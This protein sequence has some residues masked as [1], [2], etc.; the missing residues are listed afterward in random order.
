[1][2]ILKIKPR[3]E[4]WRD[5]SSCFSWPKIGSMIPFR[6]AYAARHFFVLSFRAIRYFADRL[7]RI[8]PR[9]ASGIS[10]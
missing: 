4:N 7:A 1:M 5:P 10:S 6:F 9:G 2:Y 8:R 3:G